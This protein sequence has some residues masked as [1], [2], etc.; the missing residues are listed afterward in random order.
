MVAQYCNLLGAESLFA[1][2]LLQH[3]RRIIALLQ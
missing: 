3:S 1:I 2:R